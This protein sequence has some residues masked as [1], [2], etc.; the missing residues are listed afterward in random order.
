MEHVITSFSEFFACLEPAIFGYVASNFSIKEFVAVHEA[1]TS[2]SVFRQA[3]H[4]RIRLAMHGRFNTV[5]Y[6]IEQGANKDARCGENWTSLH[7]AV[8]KEYLDIVK[9]LVEQGANIEAADDKNKTP[10][11]YAAQ[12][13]RLNILKY[14]VE[15]GANKAATDNRRMTPLH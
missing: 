4:S 5:K 13:G 6:L 7:F 1:F 15:H 11:L 14:L 2:N 12:Y 3:W 9:Y 10:A 8:A